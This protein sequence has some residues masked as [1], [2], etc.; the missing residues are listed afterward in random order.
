MVYI[1]HLFIFIINYN[2]LAASG[3]WL[4]LVSLDFQITSNVHSYQAIGHLDIHDLYTYI[5]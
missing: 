3:F 5:I 2:L 4:S 1:I